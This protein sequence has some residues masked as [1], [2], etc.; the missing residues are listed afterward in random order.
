MVMWGV[1]QTL[2]WGSS[3]YLSALLAGILHRAPNMTCA[4]APGYIF[5]P[6][7]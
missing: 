5:E 3:Y 7:G 2:T 4:F 1:I 6:F